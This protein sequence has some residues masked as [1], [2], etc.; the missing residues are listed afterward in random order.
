MD[1]HRRINGKLGMYY[2]YSDIGNVID[3]KIVDKNFFIDIFLSIKRLSLK[4]F[5]IDKLYTIFIKIFIF[6]SFSKKLS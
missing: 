5:V 6:K 4:I 2:T 1:E 3:K